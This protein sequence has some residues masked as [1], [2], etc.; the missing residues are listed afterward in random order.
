MYNDHDEMYEVDDFDEDIK[1]RQ[2]LIEEAKAIDPEADW[3]EVFREISNLKRRW[4][5]IHYW[6]S[7][8][9]D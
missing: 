9:E 4:K 8:Y 1:R 3:N 2:A 6:E 7:D 5:Q